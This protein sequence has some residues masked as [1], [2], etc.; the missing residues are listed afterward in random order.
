MSRFGCANIRNGKAVEYPI[1]DFYRLH[2]TTKW[3]KKSMGTYFAF[4]CFGFALGAICAAVGFL[5]DR[6]G[7]GK[8]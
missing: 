1:R 6:K 4:L 2:L 7:S 5:I 3:R 8:E